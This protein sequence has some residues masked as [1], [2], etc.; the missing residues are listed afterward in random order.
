MKQP[1]NSKPQQHRKI[2][3][4]ERGFEMQTKEVMYTMTWGHLG[5]MKN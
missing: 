3:I 1:H 4:V 5:L 2:D